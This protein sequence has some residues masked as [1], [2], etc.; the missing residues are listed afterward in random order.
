MKKQTI[1]LFSWNV[2]GI[3]AGI[4][5]GTFYNF[6][7][8]YNPDILCL[9]ETKAMKEQV[10]IDLPEYKKYWHSA[11]KKGYS[12]T[13]IFSK[14]PALTITHGILPNVLKKFDLTDDQHRNG[15]SEGRVV[16]AEF[17]NFFVVGVYTPNVKEDLSR[18]NFRHTKWDP[19]FLMHIKELEKKKP[20]VFCGDLNVA[21]QEIDLARPKQNLGK[22]GFTDEERKGFDNIVSAGF[23]D[24]FRD[25][26]P[27][28]MDAYSWW[29][30]WGNARERNV[31]W[32]LDYVCVSEKIKEDVV[33]AFILPKVIGSDHCPVGVTLAV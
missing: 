9:Q 5:K 30:H 13:A 31:G 24:T 11:E 20:V 15:A 6:L 3:R 28:K 19:A 22:H 14:T 25:K 2:N 21:H 10:E 4:R 7:K 29:S 23:I 16:S 8:I 33:D 1:S 18:L 17:K 27:D 12:G 32:R 26:Y